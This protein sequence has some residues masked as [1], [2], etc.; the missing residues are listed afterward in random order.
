M[1]ELV[2]SRT[3]DFVLDLIFWVL[4][5]DQCWQNDELGGFG[6]SPKFR[7][8]KKDNNAGSTCFITL[9]TWR[10]RYILVWHSRG[11]H[12]FPWLPSSHS[13]LG[14]VRIATKRAVDPWPESQSLSQNPMNFGIFGGAKWSTLVCLFMN[15]KM[16]DLPDLDR[17]GVFT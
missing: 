4:G 8:S 2:Q 3:R 5:W 12:E 17:F 7:E 16:A 11:S 9:W 15:L 10:A 6:R 1:P 14:Q 13:I